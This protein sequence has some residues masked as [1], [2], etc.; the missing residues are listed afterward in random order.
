MSALCSSRVVPPNASRFMSSVYVLPMSPAARPVPPLITRL[1]WTSR[2]PSYEH[3]SNRS[4]MDQDHGTCDR[5]CK[6]SNHHD[7]LSACE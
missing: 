5:D 6:S 2:M 3:A 7:W 1:S 4:D